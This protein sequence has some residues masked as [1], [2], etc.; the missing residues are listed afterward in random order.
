MPWK[1]REGAEIKVRS[2]LTSALIGGVWLMSG[3]GPIFL[4][5]ER[6]YQLLWWLGGI[7]NRGERFAEER[8]FLLLARF[9]AQTFQPVT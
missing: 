8:T 3:L 1:L 4:R 7:Q 2:F 5:K 9:E 6:R